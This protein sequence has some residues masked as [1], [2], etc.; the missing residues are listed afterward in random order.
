MY[1]AMQKTHNGK[2]VGY[3]KRPS[4]GRLWQGLTCEVPVQQGLT[5]R[6]QRRWCRRF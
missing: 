5:G 6:I 2:K 3:K 1:F 4:T